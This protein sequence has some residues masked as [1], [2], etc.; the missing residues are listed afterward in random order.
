MWV[1]P[2]RAGREAVGEG[3]LA[4]AWCPVRCRS[5]HSTACGTLATEPSSCGAMAIAG[6][7]THS[8][9]SA[10]QARTPASGAGLG[11]VDSTRNRPARPRPARVVRRP[12]GARCRQARPHAVLPRLSPRRRGDADRVDAR[13]SLASSARGRRGG[14]VV[15]GHTHA[16]FDR[17]LA[18]WRVV[19]AGSVGL[20]YEGRAGA[21]W[22]LL[23]PEVEHRAPSTT[24]TA[25]F[26]RCGRAAIRTSTSW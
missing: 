1:E 25:P 17:Q 18:R 4:A 20:P 15:C 2:H 6:S 5:R 21:Y 7:W 9:A 14:R 11:H 19:N 12:C 8:M 3:D 10:R 13:A 16:Q 23:G 24:S 26:S 22:L